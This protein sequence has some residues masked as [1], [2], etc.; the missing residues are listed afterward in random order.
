MIELEL[1]SKLNSWCQTFSLVLDPG[2]AVKLGIDG[3]QRKNNHAKN[4]E[5]IEKKIDPNKN[6]E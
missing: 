3:I 4:D 5:R 2:P 6:K 1:A